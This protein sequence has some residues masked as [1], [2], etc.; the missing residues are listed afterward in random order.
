MD[1]TDGELD[2]YDDDR[3]Q[4]SKGRRLVSSCNRNDPSWKSIL[5]LYSR[6]YYQYC[7]QVLFNEFTTSYALLA[8][9]LQLDN[10]HSYS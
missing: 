10:I 7:F 3:E 1:G 4:H 2:S 5:D 8:H 9:L 6:Y